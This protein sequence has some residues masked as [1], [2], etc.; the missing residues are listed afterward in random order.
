MGVIACDCELFEICP[1]CAPSEEAYTKAAAAHN[2]AARQ[3]K[4]APSLT[5]TTVLAELESVA[6]DFGYPVDWACSIIEA[7][8]RSKFEECGDSEDNVL[9]FQVR[10]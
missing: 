1:S 5:L 3:V 4:S 9:E 6:A 8:L 7:R 2:E 10:R